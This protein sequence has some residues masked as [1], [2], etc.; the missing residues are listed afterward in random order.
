MG[1]PPTAVV[2]DHQDFDQ[3]SSAATLG[4]INVIEV[5]WR[6]WVPGVTRTED[7]AMA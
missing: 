1:S 5:R 7:Q 6:C 3:P 2:Y 4:D